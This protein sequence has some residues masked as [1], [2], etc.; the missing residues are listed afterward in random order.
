MCGIQTAKKHYCPEINCSLDC[1]R[2]MSG[3]ATAIHHRPY[4]H[5]QQEIFY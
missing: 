2:Y 1:K 3:L 5:Y 4:L